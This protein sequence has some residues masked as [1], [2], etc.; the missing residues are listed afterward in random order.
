MVAATGSREIPTLVTA[1]RDV[2]TGEEQILPWLD[3]R[4][5]DCAD[6]EEHRTRAREL[7]QR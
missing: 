2:L 3:R 6:A 5:D 1:Q 7:V 4:F